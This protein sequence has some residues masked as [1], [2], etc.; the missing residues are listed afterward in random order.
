MCKTHSANAFWPFAEANESALCSTMTRELLTL[1]ISAYLD[2]FSHWHFVP[3]FD[4]HDTLTN[5]ESA[6]WMQ[7]TSNIQHRTYTSFFLSLSSYSLFLLLTTNAHFYVPWKLNV[8]IFSE[9][10]HI[11][12]VLA[13]SQLLCAAFFFCVAECP[14]QSA[15]NSIL[16]GNFSEN[17]F[18]ID[19]FGPRKIKLFEHTVWESAQNRYTGFNIPFLTIVNVSIHIFCVRLYTSWSLYFKSP[20][21]YHREIALP[22]IDFLAINLSNF[23]VIL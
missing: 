23:S 8:W 12:F 19:C 20:I 3:S 13:V 4:T 5:W 11:A 18:F 10:L 21:C 7:H 9:A 2:D 15:Y 17:W 14:W 6:P 1:D 16:L 22:L